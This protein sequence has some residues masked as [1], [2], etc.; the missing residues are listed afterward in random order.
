M[1]SGNKSLTGESDA[2]DT[3]K[4]YLN[5]LVCGN[6]SMKFIYETV[7]IASKDTEITCARYHCTGCEE[8]KSDSCYKIF[9]SDYGSKKGLGYRELS[10]KNLPVDDELGT[11]Y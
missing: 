4:K 11:F 7:S 8:G 9:C 3:D 5:R 6:G 2:N 1:Y 10:I